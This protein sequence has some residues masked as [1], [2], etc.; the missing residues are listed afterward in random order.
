MLLDR[1]RT[2]VKRN[3]KNFDVRQKSSPC[4]TEGKGE[5]LGNDTKDRDRGVSEV[6]ELVQTLLKSK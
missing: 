3:A 5:Q 4:L 1:E 6:E 2:G